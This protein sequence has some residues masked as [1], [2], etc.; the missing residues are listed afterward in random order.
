MVISLRFTL[1]LGLSA[2][3]LSQNNNNNS[4]LNF[5]KPKENEVIAANSTYLIEWT[6]QLTGRGTILLLA[7][8]T[9]DS[10][11]GLWEIANTIDV[12]AGSFSW[13]VA[14][15]TKGAELLNFYG[16]NFSLT[17]SE[18]GVYISSPFLISTPGGK[19]DAGNN[20]VSNG[21]NGDAH[22]DG[23]DDNDDF[24]AG[25]QQNDSTVAP[26]GQTSQRG[27]TTASSVPSSTTSDIAAP[28]S[29]APTGT[30]TST[31]GS[32]SDGD[33]AN[34]SVSSQPSTTTAAIPSSSPTSDP[35]LSGGA[36]AGIVTGGAAALAV[37]G[38]L[39][40]LVVYYRRKLLAGKQ[41]S[42]SEKPRGSVID[43][44]FRKAE[45]DTEGHEIIITRVYELDSTREIQ[46]A[47]GTMKPV[48][49]DGV[50]ARPEM[51]VARVTRDGVC[52]EECL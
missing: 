32:K 27:G 50:A 40:A 51:P 22:T 34:T 23:D 24:N 1:L 9:L 39:V 21:L 3:V 49:L 20:V 33:A 10:L 14:Y 7:G 28:P 18:D 17:G 2:S 26:T 13:S 35:M 47:D 38:F 19:R 41:P 12:A 4:P 52:T 29:S 25:D 31:T 46:E 5:L 30:G 42:S 44:K 45:L 11:S 37:F 16:L 36:I 43:G 15:P 8:Q 6:T 48:E